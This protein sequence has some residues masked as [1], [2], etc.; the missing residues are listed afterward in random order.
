MMYDTN[1]DKI[2]ELDGIF[3]RDAWRCKVNETE[4]YEQ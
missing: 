2:I 4:K 3:S 1:E